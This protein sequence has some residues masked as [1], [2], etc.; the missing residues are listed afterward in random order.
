MTQHTDI[1]K[2]I[3]DLHTKIQKQKTDIESDEKNIKRGWVT[4]AVYVM[5]TGKSVNIQVAK[6]E[7]IV[8]A[9]ADLISR[10]ENHE[11]AC[12]VLGVDNKISNEFVNF[13]DDWVKDFKKRLST[14]LVKEK[15]SKLEKLEK[16]LESIMSEDKKRTMELEKIMK[17]FNEED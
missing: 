7:Q 11:K 15:K 6:K 5:S 17:E 10:K 4:N 8:E 1:D 16:R 13:F 3:D 9:A 14:I 12:L 2:V